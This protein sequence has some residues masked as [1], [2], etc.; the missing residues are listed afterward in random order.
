MPATQWIAGL[1]L[2]IVGSATV[3]AYRRSPGSG[4]VEQ[5][6]SI[7]A[8]T[9]GKQVVVDFYGLQVVLALFMVTHALGSGAWLTLSVCLA[10]MPFLGA[11]AAAAYWLLAVTP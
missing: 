1:V 3:W 11:S 9:W 4:L 5:F 8:L 2:L 7:L 6:R 10:L